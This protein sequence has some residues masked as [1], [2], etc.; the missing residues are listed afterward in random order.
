L[1]CFKAIGLIASEKDEAYG[2]IALA[3]ITC[4]EGKTE[5]ELFWV[6]CILANMALYIRKAKI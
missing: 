2:K 6:C 1:L 4:V 5:F 3:F